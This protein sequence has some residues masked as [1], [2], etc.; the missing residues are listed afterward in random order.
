MILRR[1]T[2]E[3]LD[4]LPPDAPEAR[5]SRRDL[6]ALNALMGHRRAWRSWLRRE[7]ASTPP[8]AIAELGAG[9]G[10][11]VAEN[12]LTTFPDGN[13]ATLFLVDR[14][15]C[16]A[17]GTLRTLQHAGWSVRVEKADVFDWLSEPRPLDAICANLFLHHFD[18]TALARLLALASRAAPLFAAMEPRRAWLGLAG[19]AALPLMD[20]HPVTRHDARVSVEAGFCGRELSAL[21]PRA[22]W[23][24]EERRAL[25]FSHWFCA[26]RT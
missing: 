8:R 20:A 23:I 14:A 1:L 18:D 13:G 5:A 4:A 3:L 26:R 16:V 15:P 22:G 11:I 9:D 6:H 7:F 12:L 2:P 10:A 21:W 19:V 24:C 25:P 17:D